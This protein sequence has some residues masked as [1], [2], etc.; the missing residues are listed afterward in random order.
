MGV[1]IAQNAGISKA[2]T[3]GIKKSI[4]NIDYG[5]LSKTLSSL[6]STKLKATIG[7]AGIA[8]EF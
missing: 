3:A 2:L 6:M 1:E 4:G 8:T 5:G 7:I